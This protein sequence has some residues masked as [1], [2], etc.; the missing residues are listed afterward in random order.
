MPNTET[1]NQ[2]QLILCQVTDSMNYC[3]LLHDSMNY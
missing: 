1:V 2:L 3:T